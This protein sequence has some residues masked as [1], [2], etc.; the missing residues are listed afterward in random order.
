MKNLKRKLMLTSLACA[1]DFIRKK[2]AEKLEA[3]S[4]IILVV[5]LVILMSVFY[6]TFYFKFVQ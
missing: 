6:T 1:S 2:R 3:G 4:N 5:S